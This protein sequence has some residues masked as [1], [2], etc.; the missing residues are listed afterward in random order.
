M[1]VLQALPASQTAGD[2]RVR[3][4]PCGASAGR[5]EPW[6]MSSDISGVFYVRKWG[7]LTQPITATVCSLHASFGGSNV[8]EA[9]CRL[10]N[11]QTLVPVRKTPQVI[12]T[13]CP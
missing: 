6:K 7:V 5:T 10:G 2:A 1:A 4:V 9:V 12:R 11:D 3:I 8:Q 13:A